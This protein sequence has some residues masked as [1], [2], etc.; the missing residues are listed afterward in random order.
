MRLTATVGGYSRA[1]EMD[2]K[3]EQRRRGATG[4]T[5]SEGKERSSQNRLTHGM[6]CSEFR[7]L[8]DESREAYE[9]LWQVWLEEYDDGTEA[10]RELIEQVVNDHW[11]MKRADKRVQQVEEAIEESGIDVV[12]WTDEHHKR[13]SLM[14]RYRNTAKRDF[15]RSRRALEQRRGARIR[16]RHAEAK[17]EAW[18]EDRD[19]K[20]AAKR[21]TEDSTGRQ[22]KPDGTAATEGRISLSVETSQLNRTQRHPTPVRLSACATKLPFNVRVRA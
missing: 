18:N 6:R 5:T 11:L 16:E 3:Q 22:T 2:S 20:I 4:P 15:E 8:K 17:F 13:L 21:Q 14:H 9:A 12:D 19:E 1:S 10:C 7:L